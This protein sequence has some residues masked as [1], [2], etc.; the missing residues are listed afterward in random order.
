MDLSAFS[1]FPLY[2]HFKFG[3][4]VW[5]QLPTSEVRLVSSHPAEIK[6]AR[7]QLAKIMGSGEL[8]ACLLCCLIVIQ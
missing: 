4:L 5:L 3:F 8:E 6:P 1:R 2:Y 7:T